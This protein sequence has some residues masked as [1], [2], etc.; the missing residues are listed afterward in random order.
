MYVC[1]HACISTYVPALNLEVRGQFARVSSLLTLCRSWRVNSGCQA[2]Q[3]AP[4]VSLQPSGTVASEDFVLFTEVMSAASFAVA[5]INYSGSFRETDLLWFTFG[6]LGAWG[7]WA[8]CIQS[9]NR[10]IN[11]LYCCSGTF[12]YFSP[13]AQ[14]EVH[15][16]SRSGSL[17]G[18]VHRVSRS[19]HIN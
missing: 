3:K 10:A 15:G 7:S 11:H 5:L 1:A 6:V 14:G 9:G 4:W 12:S 16:V 2:Q 19:F 8:H 13:R 18:E 17:Q